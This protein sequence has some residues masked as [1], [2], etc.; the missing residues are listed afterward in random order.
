MEGIWRE[1]KARMEGE[2]REKFCKDARINKEYDLRHWEPK[3]KP[4][5]G[6]GSIFEH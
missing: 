5:A 6:Q 3:T 2:G 4:I 1:N